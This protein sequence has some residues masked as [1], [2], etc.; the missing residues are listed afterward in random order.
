MSFPPPH[1]VRALLL[2]T[3]G[4]AWLRQTCSL[5]DAAQAATGMD[6]SH[7]LDG[8]P[9]GD[10]SAL[11]VS[12][13]RLPAAGV[14]ALRLALPVPGDLSGLSGPQALNTTALEAGE[15]VLLEGAQAGLVPHASAP[16]EG[17][18]S[19][20]WTWHQAAE[21][22]L[23]HES[24]ADAARRFKTTMREAT[25]ALSELSVAGMSPETAARIG[26]LRQA[27]PARLP[28]PTTFQGS[29]RDLLE[30]AWSLSEILEL[31]SRDTGTART[32]SEIRHRAEAL[33]GVT[34]AARHAV[35]AAANSSAEQP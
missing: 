9:W 12:F 16:G 13:G 7:R 17:A 11:T 15:V 21:G 20:R 31:A 2:V 5:D 19:V 30:Q 4:N 29:G 18:P 8:A 34:Q 10:D 35:V 26:Q 24:T 27:A 14:R 33:R 22:R 1:P 25:D 23:D 3:W 6:E 32:A 28:L